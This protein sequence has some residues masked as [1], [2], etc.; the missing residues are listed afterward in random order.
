MSEKTLHRAIC[1]Y[2]RLQYPD[3]QFNS[4]ASGVRLTIKPATEMKALRSS[5]GFPDLMIFE[6]RAGYHALFIEI[7]AEGTV[8]KIRNGD[9]IADKHVRE[10]AAFMEVINKKGY[11]AEF[12]VGFD[13]AKA[14][15]DGYLRQK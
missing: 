14:I 3:V 8:L 4:D 13:N 6:P 5:R 10:Q 2:I 15:I 9:W 1:D 11:R 7:K 12:A